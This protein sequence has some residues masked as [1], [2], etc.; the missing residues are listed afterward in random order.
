MLLAI[1]RRETSAKLANRETDADGLPSCVGPTRPHFANVHG[2]NQRRLSPRTTRRRPVARCLQ[3]AVGRLLEEG[4]LARLT[5]G[6]RAWQGVGAVVMS[7]TPNH[8]PHHT[9]TL[10]DAPL[11][12]AGDLLRGASGIG[13][14]DLSLA[15]GRC[16][17]CH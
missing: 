3:I 11:A 2:S 16:H 15:G 8:S 12:G 14:L 1:A 5:R 7:N 13:K 6:E 17:F 4:S 9:P 10:E